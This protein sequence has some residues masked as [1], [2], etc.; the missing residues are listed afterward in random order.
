MATSL[1]VGRQVSYANKRRQCSFVRS[2]PYFKVRGC[3]Y[4]VPVSP[5][6]ELLTLARCERPSI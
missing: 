4:M 1:E 6:S 5:K 2:V 3:N